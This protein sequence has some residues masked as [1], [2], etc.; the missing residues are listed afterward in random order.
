MESVGGGGDDGGCCVV[1]WW[2]R[3]GVLACW[4]GCVVVWW[5]GNG[6]E[7]RLRVTVASHELR[8]RLTY[9]VLG[10]KCHEVDATSLAQARPIGVPFHHARHLAEGGGAAAGYFFLL[11]SCGGCY[12]CCATIR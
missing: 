8:L 12:G 3:G 6:C 10:A 1:V 4:T 2:R 7:L 5:N 11:A 9:H